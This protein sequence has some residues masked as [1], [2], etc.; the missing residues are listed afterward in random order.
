MA[1]TEPGGVTR[2]RV[3]ALVLKLVAAGGLVVDAVVH[4]SLAAEYDA[5]RGS[6]VSQGELFRLQAAAA[7]AAALVV[8]VGRGRFAW[9][10]G[11]VVAGPA[12]AAVL[13]YRYL[14]PGALG[15]LPDMYEPFW[16]ARKAL[17]TA[18]EAAAVLACVAGLLLR[19]PSPASAPRAGSLTG[20]RKAP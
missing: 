7:L 4:L 17:A 14:D 9:L 16:F 19:R 10:T 3:E 12:L 15:P 5:N 18:A 11:G 2:A 8:L 6:L 1:G 20:R 13:F